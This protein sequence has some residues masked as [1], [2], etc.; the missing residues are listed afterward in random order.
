MYAIKKI[1]ITLFTQL[2]A[3]AFIKLLGKRFPCGVYSRAAFIS[4]SYFLNH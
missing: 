4:K 3:A 1:V 2:N